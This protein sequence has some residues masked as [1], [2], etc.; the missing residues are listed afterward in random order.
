MMI[1][2]IALIFCAFVLLVAFYACES[3]GADIS[4][5]AQSTTQPATTTTTRPKPTTTTTIPRPTV[6]EPPVSMPDDSTAWANYIVDGNYNYIADRLT[7]TQKNN[8]KNMCAAVGCK[9]EFATDYTK[10]TDAKKNVVYYSRNFGEDTLIAEPEF[11]ILTL[12]RRSGNETVFVYKGA[13]IFDFVSY[14][15]QVEVEGFYYSS[16]SSTDYVKGEGIFV[17][18]DENGNSVIIKLVGEMIVIALTEV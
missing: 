11:G 9:V 8:V 17:G 16:V 6:T 5:T 3:D 12:A 7:K 4:T 2:R 18:S 13:K 14:I 15:K 1:K 10:V